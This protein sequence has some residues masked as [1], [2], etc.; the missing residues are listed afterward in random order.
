MLSPERAKMC[1]RIGDKASHGR[2][3]LMGKGVLCSSSRPLV[4]G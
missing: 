2:D 3:F 4:L 1:P